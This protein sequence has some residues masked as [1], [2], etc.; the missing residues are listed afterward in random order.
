MDSSENE[1]CALFSDSNS[2]SSANEDMIGYG[3]EF[4]Y[5]ETEE[6]QVLINQVLSHADR[7]LEI[8][9]EDH[10]L[11]SI[12]TKKTRNVNE[13]I[14]QTKK[15]MK[16]QTHSYSIQI[17]LG[18]ILK[19]IATSSYELF[20]AAQ[21]SS[22]LEFAK[23][24]KTRKQSESVIEEIKNFNWENFMNTPHSGY[25]VVQLA[26]A[27]IL[28]FKDNIPL[29]SQCKYNLSSL[30]DFIKKNRYIVSGNKNIK[31]GNECDRICFFRALCEHYCRNN[32]KT[33]GKFKSIIQK[34]LFNMFLK[35]IRKNICTKP[36]DFNGV[37]IHEM[38]LCEKIFNT[39]I[40][41][42]VFEEICK[43]KNFPKGIKSEIIYLSSLKTPKNGTCHL[44]RHYEH[45]CY[46][47]DLERALGFISCEMCN[48]KLTKNNFAK[49]VKLCANKIKIGQSNF[50]QNEI[51]HSAQ[52]YNPK[53]EIFE[54]IE[55]EFG[56]KINTTLKNIHFLAVWDC[57]CFFENFERFEHRGQAT[58]GKSE[59]KTYLIGVCSNVPNFTQCKLFWL[60]ELGKNFVS[61]FVEYVI[62][63]SKKQYLILKKQLKPVFKKL[64]SKLN[65]AKKNNNS[66]GI[67]IYDNL[68][69]DLDKFC[70]QIP[71]ISY[72]GSK[73]DNKLNRRDLGPILFEKYGEHVKLNMKNGQYVR[74]ITPDIIFLDQL[75]FLSNKTNYDNFI[76]NTLGVRLKSIMPYEFLT[77]LERLN[78]PGLPDYDYWNSDLKS[79]NILDI[80]YNNFENLTKKG[81]SENEAIKKLGLLEK[82]VKGI[83]KLEM[84]R[85]FFK[86]KGFKT[87]KDYISYYIEMDTVPFVNACEKQSKLYYDQFNINIYRCYHSLPSVA[88][89]IAFREIKTPV[90]IPSRETYKLM[91]EKMIG[92]QSLLIQLEAIA[93][94]SKIRYREFGEE[95]LFCKSIFSLDSS[96]H[97]GKAMSMGLPVG[98]E[99]IRKRENGFKLEYT[100]KRYTHYLNAERILAF[101]AWDNNIKNLETYL[102]GGERICTKIAS[103]YKPDGIG[104][105]CENNERKRVIVEIFGDKAHDCPICFKDKNLFHPIKKHKNGKKMRINEVIE[106]DKK[107]IEALKWE[108]ETDK[109]I[110]V[111]CCEFKRDYENVEGIFHEKFKNFLKLHQDFDQDKKKLSEETLLNLI[112]NGKLFGFLLADY[113]CPKWLQEKCELYPIIFKKAFVSREDTGEIM[114]EYLTKNGLMKNPHRELIT[115]HFGKNLLVGS[116]LVKFYLEMGVKIVNTQLF[117]QY[118]ESFDFKNIV[119]RACDMRF[120]A[121]N[122]AERII[123]ESCKSIVVS[124]YGKLLQCPTKYSCASYMRA[125]KLVNSLYSRNFISCEFVGIL[126]NG[127]E[128]YEIKRKPKTLHFSSPIAMGFMVLT[129]SKVHLLRFIYDFLIKCMNPK[130]FTFFTSQTDSISIICCEESMEKWFDRQ[131]KPDMKKIFEKLK[132]HYIAVEGD[133]EEAKKSKY[134][135][136]KFKK[137]FEGDFAVAC[138]CKTYIV[139]KN[140]KI[141]KCAAL[142]VPYS[143]AKNLNVSMLHNVLRNHEPL[144]INY[145]SFN[146]VVGRMLS[147]MMY[148]SC[149]TPYYV[150]RKLCSDMSTETLDV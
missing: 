95:S 127:E 109:I 119:Q 111:Y 112:K 118:D 84:L 41:I 134:E 81:M 144:V 96:L 32:I 36:R 64:K 7:Y 15:V 38:S 88:I 76:F 123:G 145:E 44:L 101:V 146:Y 131:V 71:L 102:R 86:N 90:Y 110:V 74:I 140:N 97:Y 39:S 82:P 93:N 92:G 126:K 70:K 24:I 94:V 66:Y 98:M 77:D 23:H 25:T 62:S 72:N 9:Q 128:L 67:K 30:P 106:F 79:C 122:H 27:R 114:N 59:L 147:E 28:I 2:S 120:R 8:E 6:N 132:K 29:A 31:T 137:E 107:R 19:D 61:Y 3:K 115:S 53:M 11:L 34:R 121:R 69:E 52:K 12:Y 141:V 80:D 117:I 116:P 50:L 17:Q 40:N 100:D 54:K 37:F 124:S 148:K 91:R 57:E 47:S 113:Y 48:L 78:F 125:S 26:Y 56:E 129:Q 10:Q 99:R 133:S 85:K 5:P 65:Q 46:I 35:K 83:E 105:I 58:F 33:F 63:I 150:K 108:F 21:N 4:N 16:I 103:K 130:S 22:M 51:Y 75:S 89:K 14:K 142:G 135:A 18:Y 138:G 104:E 43:T 73:F 139:S 149:I 87:F 1:V 55:K 13:L 136:G 60:P 20:Y 68:I 143:A 45:V 42:Y 49:H